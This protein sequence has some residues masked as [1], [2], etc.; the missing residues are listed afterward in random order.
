MTPRLVSLKLI[1]GTI[2]AIFLLLHGQS[3]A[4]AEIDTQRELFR[5]Q[6]LAV[7]LDDLRRVTQTYLQPE[8]ASTALVTNSSQLDST[9]SLR[10]ELNLTVR[11]L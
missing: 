9:A 8:L 5:Q 4:S 1:A 3:A 11:E 7:S 10:E 2:A 6:I